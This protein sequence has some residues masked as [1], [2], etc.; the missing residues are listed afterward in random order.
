[1]DETKFSRD[2]AFAWFL[3][4][5][6]LRLGRQIISMRPIQPDAEFQKAAL[7]EESAYEA[8]YKVGLSRSNYNI[9]LIDYAFLQFGFSSNKAWRLA[10][11]PNPWVSG[12][13]RAIEK[14]SE[15]ETLEEEGVATTE[16]VAELFGEM[17]YRGF[18]PPIRFDYAEDHYKEIRHPA[19]HIHIG[20]YPQSRLA[21][22]TKLT[23]STFS[24]FI[25]KMFYAAKWSGC[26]SFFSEIPEAECL[27]LKLIER[28]SASGPVG[29]FSETEYRALHIGRRID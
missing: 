12:V 11:Y 13:E 29:S 2:I 9:L 24:L 28:L 20:M 21:C 7:D 6:R 3:L 25:A 8:V 4:N 16:E 22:S 10:Y 18:V 14:I 27:D 19:A 15:W 5:S 26:S 1:M 23:P 17:P